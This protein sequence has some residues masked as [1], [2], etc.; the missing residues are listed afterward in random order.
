MHG[1]LF[2]FLNPIVDYKHDSNVLQR[3]HP[4]QDPSC[5]ALFKNH[6]L[7]QLDAYFNRVQ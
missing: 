6:L 4:G 7:Q 5:F 3:S 2:L 1:H